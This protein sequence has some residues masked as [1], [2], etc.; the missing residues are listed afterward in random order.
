MIGK[1]A[2]TRYRV[3]FHT[4]WKVVGELVVGKCA[5]RS[6]RVSFH[7]L[8]KNFKGWLVRNFV[9]SHARKYC[10]TIASLPY[11]TLP[12]PTYI[13]VFIGFAGT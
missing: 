12:P 11:Q 10:K 7:T 8:F 2:V 9:H 3:S 6:E 13:L 5:V 1:G 4:S